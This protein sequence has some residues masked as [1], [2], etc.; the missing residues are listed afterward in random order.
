MDVAIYG[1]VVDIQLQSMIYLTVTILYRYLI[2]Y[3]LSNHADY[4]I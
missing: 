1:N 3:K 2:I 4:C